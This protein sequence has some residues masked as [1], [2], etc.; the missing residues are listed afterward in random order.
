MTHISSGEHRIG[1][2]L[3]QLAQQC[4]ISE[5]EVKNACRDFV[6]LELKSQQPSGVTAST[7]YRFSPFRVMRLGPRQVR[8]AAIDMV[9][10]GLR[11]ASAQD[12]AQEAANASVL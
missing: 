4:S 3:C 7:F 5:S 1:E 9:G 2:D 6:A 8:P 12:L 11:V 10:T